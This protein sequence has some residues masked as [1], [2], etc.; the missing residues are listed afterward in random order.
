MEFFFQVA[1]PVRLDELS[2]LLRRNFHPATAVELGHIGVK[3]PRRGFMNGK[4]DLFFEHGGKYWI[5]DWKTNWLGRPYSAYNQD[6]LAADMIA[7]TYLM[8]ASVYALAVDKYLKFRLP[9]YDYERN[10]GG[11]FYLFVRGMDGCSPNQGAFKMR[12]EQSFIRELS[13]IFPGGAQ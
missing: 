12:P 3:A 1:D 9:D 8:Q 7:K 11:V 5:I 2:G 10:F 4:I 6:A 13:E